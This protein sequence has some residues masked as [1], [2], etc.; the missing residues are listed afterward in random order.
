[1][2]N[3]LQQFSQIAYSFPSTVQNT[4]DMAVRCAK[5][6]GVYVEC[7]VA[8]GAQVMAMQQALSDAGVHKHIYAFD[9]FEGIP[10]GCDRDKEQPGI[11]NPKHD[12]TL[13]QSVRLV[14]SGVTVHSLENV[15]AN[16]RKLGV[17]TDKINFIKGW[18]QDTV[19]V[20]DTGNIALLRLDGD[21]YESTKICLE[22]LYP[23][24]VNNGIVI[25]DDYAL[26]G[27]RTAVDEYFIDNMPELHNVEGGGGVVWF[28][29]YVK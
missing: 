18:F 4:Y 12:T 20:T 27:C 26:E 14:S 23:K 15:Y 24:V 10:L 3:R 17:D 7:G 21:L 22:Y 19:C 2:N 11:G 9:S 13:P 5:L 25:I 1:M 6:P 8:A 16:F 28:K 29:K